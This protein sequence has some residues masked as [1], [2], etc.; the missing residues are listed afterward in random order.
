M[1]DPEQ[2]KYLKSLGIPLWIPRDYSGSESLD[3]VQTSVEVEGEA[4]TGQEEP[5]SQPIKLSDDIAGMN[6]DD[7]K[8]AVLGCTSCGLHVERAQAVFGTGNRDASL[9]VIGEAPGADEDIQGEPF[10]GRAGQ[11]LDQMLQAIGYQRSSVYIAN[12]VKCRPPNNRNPQPEEALHCAPYL[13]RQIALIQPRVILAAGKVAAQNLLQSDLPVGKMR[14]S[15]YRYAA[16]D[17]PVIV[18]YH[19]AYLLRSP[20]EKAKSWQDLKLVRSYLE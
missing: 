13:H 9:M 12:I 8:Q 17:I 7:L 11:L 20:K 6:W 10:V 5:R 15:H 3:E 16:L 19:P 18:T 4:R 2:I 1:Q 14:G